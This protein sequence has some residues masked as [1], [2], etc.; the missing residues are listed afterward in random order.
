[1]VLLQFV[2]GFLSRG[3]LSNIFRQISFRTLFSG[4]SRFHE[5]QADDTALDII[6]NS[7]FN[8]YKMIQLFS[9]FEHLD[10]VHYNFSQRILHP[11]K[12]KLRILKHLQKIKEY[13]HQ[14]T[15]VSDEERTT[16]NLTKDKDR[17]PSQRTKRS[18]NNKIP[19]FSF[20]T[21]KHEY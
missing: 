10:T 15:N 14:D 18:N 5:R 12:E 7:R 2:L 20:L 6:L 3:L 1:M 19:H 4:Y 11:H 17:Y 13:S 9:D 21:R 8:P 16:D